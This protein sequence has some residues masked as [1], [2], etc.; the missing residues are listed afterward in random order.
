MN[1][2]MCDLAE[3]TMNL[4]LK[5]GA[6][7]CRVSAGGSRFLEI[8][9]R[10]HRPETIKEATE[11][12]LSIELFVKGRYTKQT[13]SDLRREALQAFITQAVTQTKLLAEDAYRSLPDAD[14]YAGRREIDLGI[15]DPGYDD[16]TAEERHETAGR[17]EEACYR[18]GGDKIIS[19]SADVYDSRNESVMLSSNGFA[20]SREKTVFVAGASVAMQD[21]GDR[22]PNG[23]HY[24]SAVRRNGLATPEAIG[25]EA[26]RRTR[27]LLGAKK[28]RTETLPIIVENRVVS[29]LLGGFLAGMA[30]SNVQQK[31]SFLAD[32]KGQVIGSQVFTLIDDPFIEGG[33]GSRLYDGDGLAARRRVMI[34]NGRLNAFFID[35][36]YSRKLGCEPTTGGAANLVIPPGRRSM[37]QIMKDLGRGVLITGFI[38]GNSN[39]TTGDMSVG[40]IGTLF[41]NGEW[42]QPVAEMNIADNHLEFWRKLV[43]T[44]DDPWVYSSNRTPSLVFED[45]VVSGV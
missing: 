39:S 40:I 20:G 41:E 6:D 18:E 37:G 5:A 30:G 4:A 3:T 10:K 12:G 42:V 15:V 38:G 2:A 28:I 14:Y 44:A 32:R 7:A 13:T 17:V 8:G 16:L 33:L 45:V 23:Y 24:I 1:Q 26:V 27:N 22:R 25:A 31:Q 21:E 11:K 29:R 35:W 34:E 36:Y 19:V 43:E 9:Y